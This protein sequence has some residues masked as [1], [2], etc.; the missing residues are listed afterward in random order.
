MVL[1]YLVCYKIIVE[2]EDVV[3]V[4]ILGGL[5]YVLFLY[6]MKEFLNGG[7]ILIE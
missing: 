5:V 1:F 3:L 6:F 4:C 7:S 2:G